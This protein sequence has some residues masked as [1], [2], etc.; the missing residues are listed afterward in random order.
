MCICHVIYDVMFSP[1]QETFEAGLS[2]FE[3]EGVG[4][5]T[6]LKDRL[7]AAQHPQTR[8]IKDRHANVISRLVIIIDIP[9]GGGWVD[10]WM[11]LIVLINAF[12]CHFI[13]LYTLD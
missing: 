1:V 7:V 8:Q 13:I 4:G 11:E 3:Q 12:V 5:L 2:S 10:G 9:T 6:S